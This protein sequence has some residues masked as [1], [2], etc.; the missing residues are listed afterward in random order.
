M[1]VWLG[2]AIYADTSVVSLGHG[3][4]VVE[5]DNF[6]QNSPTLS[7]LRSVLLIYFRLDSCA[8]RNTHT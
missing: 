7:H 6:F 5:I 3:Q 1:F 8:H 4:G 2:D